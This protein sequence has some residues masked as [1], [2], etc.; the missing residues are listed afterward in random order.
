MCCVFFKDDYLGES[1]LVQKATLVLTGGKQHQVVVMPYAGRSV[2]HN[3]D[4]M[5][6]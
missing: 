6:K 1:L 4:R 5:L 2:L 3:H